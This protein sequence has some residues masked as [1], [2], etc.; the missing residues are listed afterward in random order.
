MPSPNYGGKL[1]GNFGSY[2]SSRDNPFLE[3]S[4]QIAD[5]IARLSSAQMQ[6]SASGT[7]GINSGSFSWQSHAARPADPEVRDYMSNVLGGQRNTLDDYVRRAAGASIKRG[8][9]TTAGGPPLDSALYQ[10]AIE[11]LA[12]GYGDRFRDAMNYNRYVKG[13]ESSQV[14]DNMRNLQNLL[15]LQQRYLSSATD[16]K[17]KQT[18]LPG[19]TTNP[20]ADLDRALKAL[21]L[22]HLRRQMEMEQWQ[23]AATKDDRQKALDEKIAAEERW[24][25]LAVKPSL[26]WGPGDAAFNDLAGIRIGYQSPWQRKMSL[27][28]RGL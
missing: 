15:S 8:G 25:G 27:N 11:S 20:D 17:Q 26:T 12:K 7:P 16:W 28:R 10:Q 23:N 24:A 18:S 14:S 13:T 21:S 22:E 3:P 5:L 1:S 9:K 2:S 4:R 6:G 19:V